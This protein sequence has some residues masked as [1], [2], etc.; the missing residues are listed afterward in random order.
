MYAVCLTGGI[1]SGK[2]TISNLFAEL[3]VVVIDTDIVSRNLLEPT[4]KAYQ[5]VVQHFGSDI[6]DSKGL[7][8][9]A[10]LREIVFSEPNHKIWLEAMMHPLIYQRCHDAMREYSSA[11]YLLVV[12]PLLF[13]TNFQPLADRI[14][15]VDCPRDLQ[16]SRLISRDHIDATLANKMLD[17]Q[18]TNADRL[19]RAHDVIDNHE[20]GI[21]LRVQVK[22]LHR[23]YSLSAQH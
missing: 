13:E 1:A 6:L 7:I 16:F 20:D 5:Q 12:I 9:R 10:R 22:K 23:Q 8:D 18:F 11:V 2:T 21:D 3:G 14:L 19:A 4:E 17:Q 15:A